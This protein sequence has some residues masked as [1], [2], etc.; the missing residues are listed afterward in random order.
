MKRSTRSSSGKIV[1][2]AD[3]SRELEAL[4][5]VAAKWFY[6]RAN[7]RRA[8]PYARKLERLIENSAVI[9][10]RAM[11]ESILGNEVFGL[12]AEIKRDWK[13]AVRFRRKKVLLVDALRK[14]ARTNA[15]VPADVLA[16]PAYVSACWL[17][18][19]IAYQMIDD[20]RKADAAVRNAQK[21]VRAGGFQFQYLPRRPS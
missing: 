9:D 15:A 4:Y 6:E 14:T 13:S 19:A 20:R 7:R 8:L 1:R 10:K 18:L 3:V 16:P 12:V 21:S 17:D 11:M 2:G 5:F